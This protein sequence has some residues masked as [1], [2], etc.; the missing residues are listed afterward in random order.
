M[1]DDNPGPGVD[2]Y[3]DPVLDPTRNVLDLVDAVAGVVI[4]LLKK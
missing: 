4:M 2:A 3:G 1:A